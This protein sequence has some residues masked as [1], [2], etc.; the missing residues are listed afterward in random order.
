MRNPSIL[1]SNF[2]V[3]IGLPRTKIGACFNLCSA[4]MVSLDMRVHCKSALYDLWE[5]EAGNRL[6]LALL[7]KV[8][9]SPSWR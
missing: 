6:R 4:R 1:G 9:I 3:K 2:T 5:P 8:D 7:R